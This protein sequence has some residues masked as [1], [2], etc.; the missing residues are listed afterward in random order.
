MT[1][2]LVYCDRCNRQVKNAFQTPRYTSG[3]Y[4]VTSGLNGKNQWRRYAREGERRVC[5][6]C[7]WAD[8]KYIA[9]H[10]NQVVR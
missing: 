6:S 2:V 10:G 7:M 3:F 5:D 8:P 1:Y 9:E 4:D